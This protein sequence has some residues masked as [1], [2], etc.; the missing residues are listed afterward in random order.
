VRN[1]WLLALATALACLMVLAGVAAANSLARL[2]V[3]RAVDQPAGLV[4][5]LRHLQHV[6]LEQAQRI[7]VGQHQAGLGAE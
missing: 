3:W 1:N 6:L 4:H 7:G 2:A 5:Q